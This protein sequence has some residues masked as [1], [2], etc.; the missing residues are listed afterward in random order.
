M[1]NAC[2]VVLISKERSSLNSNLSQEL[3]LRGATLKLEA[4]AAGVFF[5]DGLS[6]RKN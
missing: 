1:P 4:L 2:H 5:F 6:G 3:Q